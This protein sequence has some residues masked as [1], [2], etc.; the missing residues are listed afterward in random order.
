MFLHVTKNFAENRKFLDQNKEKKIFVC[1]PK[2][3][4]K[5]RYKAFTH[6]CASSSMILE[7]LLSVIILYF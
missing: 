5:G 6:T 4:R 1:C 2:Q 3:K 7:W